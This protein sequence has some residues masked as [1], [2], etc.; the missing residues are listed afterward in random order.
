MK[1]KLLAMMMTLT[2]VLAGCSTS[3]PNDGIQEEPDNQ[4]EATV[5]SSE[6]EHESADEQL[7]SENELEALE[8]IGEIKT[9]EGLFE[10]E[11]TFPSQFVGEATQETLNETAK[12]NGFKSIT[13]NEDGSATY[14]MTKKKYDAFIA[15]TKLSFETALDE[16]VGSED[17]PSIVSI[18]A[19]DNFTEFVV[20]TK[21]ETLSLAE[22]FS[23]MS[24][25]I[26]GGI[27]SI[28]DGEEV[29]NINVKFINED[30]GEI[31]SES[32]SS[33]MN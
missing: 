22:S 19:N 6:S 5:E 29:D 2:L 21:N 27:Y 33:E 28:F 7:E 16:M 11:L 30:S 26:M 15:E 31:I 1:I 14:V 13:L 10:V 4:T 8:A 17:F 20:V 23:S 25:Y 24:F 3:A 18:E 32:N 9:E 12:E